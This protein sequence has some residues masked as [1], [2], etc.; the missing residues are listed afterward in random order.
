MGFVGSIRGNH[1]TFNDAFNASNATA[2]NV[3]S[4]KQYAPETGMESTAGGLYRLDIQSS[5][6]S[7]TVT[8]QDTASSGAVSSSFSLMAPSTSLTAM[9]NSFIIFFYVS[10]AKQIQARAHEKRSRCAHHRW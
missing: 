10:N 2:V 9:P 8:F 5:A 3:L 1:I 4:R 7:G 6:S